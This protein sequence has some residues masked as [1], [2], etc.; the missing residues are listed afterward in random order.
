M[1]RTRFLS[2]LMALAMLLSLPVTA[3]AEE[4]R[5]TLTILISQ[6]TLV[7]D[8]E[9]NAF[10]KMI[11]DELNVNLDF[12]LLPANDVANKLSV[13]LF[14]GQKLPDIINVCM[15]LATT[16]R[17][18][19]SGAFL[20]LNEYYETLGVNVKT[21]GEMH[22]G[23]YDLI[24]C[25]DGNIY[26]IPTYAPDMHDEHRYKIWINQVWLNK[27]GLDMPETTD[28]LYEVLKAFKTQ[29]PNGNGIADEYAL[30][31]ST[32]W[33]QDPTINLTNAFI[34]EGDED[35]FI[36]ND[37]VV[38]VNY[39]KDAY[40]EALLYMRKLVQEGLLDPI[41]FTQDESQLRAMMNNEDICIVGA[42]AFT[43]NTI[44]D[45]VNC[46]YINDYVVM[47]PVAG[48]EG[49]RLSS[50]QAS[51][52]YNQWFITTDCENPELAFK[53]GDWMFDPTEEIFLRSRFGEEG[54][55]W[56][57]PEEGDLSAWGEDF[58]PLYRLDEN[59]WSVS[60][61]VHWRNNT[62][63]YALNAVQRVVWDSE[64]STTADA[65]IAK[66][67][68]A[69][70]AYDPAP[71]TYIASLAFTA[72][73]TEEIS[74]IRATLK[75]YTKECKIRFITG[76]MSIENEWDSYLEELNQIGLERF[77]EVSQIAYDRVKG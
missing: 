1:N 54:V 23:L 43:S 48:P 56:S 50:Y 70:A 58:E 71:G 21:I 5:P 77:L 52:P 49:V 53:I 2:L 12:E 24:T 59:I 65:A 18:A 76:D 74:E 32:G 42:Y 64:N 51:M 8:Y 36:V 75:T 38:D 17:F 29:D 37:G 41:S 69:H 16:Y 15:G 13:M 27:L 3:F 62:P 68:L 39:N 25:P 60:Q 34:Y 6:D 19:Q 63:T 11:E 28:E 7:E 47:T 40:K 73:E 33:S 66:G 10:T 22:P 4:E 45:V 20:P 46:P 31:G 44:M 72:E 61:N 67:V 26:S 14:S 55:H 35:H 30:V 9:T 57:R